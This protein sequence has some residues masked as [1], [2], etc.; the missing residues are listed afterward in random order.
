LGDLGFLDKK[1]VKKLNLVTKQKKFKNMKLPPAVKEL[2][3]WIDLV[4]ARIEHNFG[5]VIMSY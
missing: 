2:N 5:K 1:I 4:R 3:D